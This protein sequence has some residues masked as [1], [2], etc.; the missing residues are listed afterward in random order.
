[1]RSSQTSRTRSRL[2]AVDS[3]VMGI[4]LTSFLLQLFPNPRYGDGTPEPLQRPVPATEVALVVR[5][6]TPSGEILAGLSAVSVSNTMT[7]PAML[8]GPTPPC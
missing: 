6:H 2:S 8:H 5:T 7:T 4:F 1:M 3:T